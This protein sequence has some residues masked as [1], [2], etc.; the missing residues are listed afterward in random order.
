MTRLRLTDCVA[1]NLGKVTG[2]PWMMS[3]QNSLRCWHAKRAGHAAVNPS[4]E[5]MQ[6]RTSIVM[7]RT[8]A[9]A[10]RPPRADVVLC[11]IEPVPEEAR[12]RIVHG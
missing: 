11:K 12:A 9:R 2:V 10:L 3:K 5:C 1:I 4:F 6:N 7:S 8:Q